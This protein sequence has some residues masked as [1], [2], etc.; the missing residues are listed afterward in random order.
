MAKPKGTYV[1]IVLLKLAF[2]HIQKELSF[3]SP[4]LGLGSTDRLVINKPGLSRDVSANKMKLNAPGQSDGVSQ[5][6]TVHTRL[7]YT[8]EVSLKN[9]EGLLARGNRT[10]CLRQGNV[11]FDNKYAECN[12]TGALGKG[13]GIMGR[14]KYIR[15]IAGAANHPKPP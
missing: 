6:L 12:V 8:S 7:C 3:Y 13:R 11:H 9:L 2:L 5:V 14:N 10:R 15:D 4:T 1:H